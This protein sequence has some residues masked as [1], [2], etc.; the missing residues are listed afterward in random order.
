MSRTVPSFAEEGLKRFLHG[1]DRRLKDVERRGDWRF[2][3]EDLSDEE[4]IIRSGAGRLLTMSS[5]ADSIASGGDY[6][7]FDGIVHNRGFVGITASKITWP[8]SAVGEIQIEFAWDSYSGGGKIELEVDGAVPVWGLLADAT[9]GQVGCKR[10]SVDIQAGSTVKVKV[11][12]SSGSAKT[13]DV[14]AEF[15]IPDPIGNETGAANS[16]L[17]ADAV[18]TT[19]SPG[20]GTVFVSNTGIF[21]EWDGTGSLVLSSTPDGTG[22]ISV[23]DI[24]TV[25]VTHA[26]ASTAT[27]TKNWNPTC[28]VSDS[29]LVVD[30]TAKFEAGTNV[31]D[32]TCSDFCA[33]GNYATTAIYLVQI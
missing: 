3:D 4:L 8:V 32:L 21:F 20:P 27:Y 28:S 22:P 12:Q 15:V 19:A 6:I 1:M 17:L 9:T 5:T 11:T 23:D 16:L 26:D 30:V 18:P 24:L 14:L 13:A 29:A 7:A 33:G 10:R 31:I 2:D 25:D